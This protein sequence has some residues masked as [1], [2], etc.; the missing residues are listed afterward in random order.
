MNVTDADA[1]GTHRRLH[2][3]YNADGSVMGK[4][5]YAYRKMTCDKDTGPTCAA[6][7]ITHGGLSLKETPTWTNVKKEIQTSLHLMVLQEHRD[8]ISPEVCT[9]LWRKSL[10]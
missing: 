2:I 10:S 4:I 5:N 7:D 6:C 8:E 3:V 9:L 1:S